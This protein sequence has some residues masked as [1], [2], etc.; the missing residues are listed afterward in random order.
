M[1]ARG[2]A[3]GSQR[4]VDFGASRHLE[5]L[6]TWPFLRAHMQKGEE[7]VSGDQRM[8]NA[9]REKRSSKESA[10]GWL[11]QFIRGTNWNLVRCRA[12]P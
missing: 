1:L 4:A 10:G 2:K 12:Y 11:A 6:T 5:L 8:L 9:D 3:G 7:D